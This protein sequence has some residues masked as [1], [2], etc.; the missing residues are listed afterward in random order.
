MQNIIIW[1]SFSL[2]S[3]VAISYLEIINISVSSLIVGF[4]S[5]A[6]ILTATALSFSSMV[7][8]SVSDREF[9]LSSERDIIDKI[10]DPHDLYSE[11]DESTFSL[12][13]EKKTQKL[14]K[15][16]FVD[17]L[18]NSK[19]SMSIYR[20]LAYGLMVIGFFYLRDNHLFSPVSYILGVT[21]PIL[22]V[23]LAL[24][25]KGNSDS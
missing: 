6:M 4:F 14:Q 2:L 25:L 3:A 24:F 12:A 17:S 23:V 9:T 21:L 15:L 19:A 7:K 18:K 11:Q 13:D 8:K 20:I 10:D 1:S 5:S 16:S 22:V